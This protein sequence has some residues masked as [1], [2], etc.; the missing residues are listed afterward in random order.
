MKKDIA[1]FVTKSP[2]C[3]QMKVEH[4]KPGGLSQ[5]IS[6]PTWKWEDLNTD[7]IVSY[8]VKDYAKLYLREMVKFHEVPLSIIFDRGTQFTSQ[9]WM[10]FQKVLGTRVKLSTTFHSTIGM[11]PFEALYGRR[12]RSFLGWF[13][14]GNDALIGLELVHEAIEKF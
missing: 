11:N 7:F 1:E 9:F 4:Q 5:D 6:I 14:E 2:N 3:E 10:S 8:K 12:C 13:K